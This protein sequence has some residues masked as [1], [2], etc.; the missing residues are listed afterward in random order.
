MKWASTTSSKGGL[1][2]YFDRVFG[3]VQIDENG[4]NTWV[5]G[6]GTEAYITLRS[7]VED[8]LAGVIT[9]RVTGRF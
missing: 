2:T 5:T 4:A 8:E 1:G 7:G 6:E 3:S 9:D